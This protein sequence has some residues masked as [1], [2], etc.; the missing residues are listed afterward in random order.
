MQLNFYEDGG[1][2]VLSLKDIG[3]EDVEGWLTANVIFDYQGFAASFQIYLM[4]NDI[5]SFLDELKELSK[6]LKGKATFSTIEG[7]VSLV[8]LGDGLGHIGI[9]G[10]IRHSNDYNLVTNFEI[11]SDQ[12]FLAP[13]ISQCEKIIKE[14][15][16]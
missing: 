12:T 3:R 2:T 1:K 9:N 10:L 8:L 6:N 7:N 15:T 5:Y 4:L 16:S 14:A 13:L 11:P